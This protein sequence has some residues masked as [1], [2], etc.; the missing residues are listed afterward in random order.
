MLFP[1][2]TSRKDLDGVPG[3]ALPLRVYLFHTNIQLQTEVAVTHCSPRLLGL[4]LLPRSFPRHIQTPRKI[5]GLGEDRVALVGT[6]PRTGEASGYRKRKT[7]WCSV[8]SGDIRMI[9][10]ESPGVDHFSSRDLE[11]VRIE[12]AARTTGVLRGLRQLVR[13]DDTDSDPPPHGLR[14]ARFSARLLDPVKLGSPSLERS[15]EPDRPA[16]IVNGRLG[17]AV[18]SLAI[19]R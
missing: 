10:R 5:P 8:K 3:K 11:Y 2:P 4:S 19:S 17:G 15:P 16:G 18:S 14:R 13:E 1:R 12:D 7:R 6:F 9:P